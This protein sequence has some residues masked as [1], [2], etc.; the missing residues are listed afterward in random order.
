M[1][2]RFSEPLASISV[3]VRR[4]IITSFFGLCLFAL[5]L[6]GGMVGYH[7]F[8]KLSW[9]NAFL[10]AAMVLSGMG[11]VAPLP[12]NSAKM[13]AGFYALFCGLFFAVIIALLFTPV[14]H[15]F[16]HKF[17]VDIKPTDPT[18]QP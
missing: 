18:N 15:R 1:F 8:V 7:H 16:F 13:F 9:V 3:F 6:G 11:Q 5:S 10:N 14:I 12:D 2:E 17:H 4:L